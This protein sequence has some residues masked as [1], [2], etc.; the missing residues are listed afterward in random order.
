M[1]SGIVEETGSVLSF[2]PGAEAWRLIISATAVTKDLQMGDSIAVNGC[3]LTAVAF[4]AERIEFDLLAETVRLT[5]FNA[6]Q[7][8]SKVNL[9]RSLRF[10]GKLGGHFVTGHIDAQGT[11]VTLEPRGQDWYL[12]IE[13]PAE[14]M[15]YLVYKGSI[16]IDGISLTVADVDATGFSVWIIPH[17]R[18]VTNL[19][20]RKAGD[21]VNLEFDLLAKYVERLIAKQV[22]N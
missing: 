7:P 4:S 8:G 17:T 14:Y 11:L 10:D 9:E 3:C 21:S 5:N 1:F 12:R 15:H 13:P 18:N 6:L 19:C 20:T 2:A 16:A 22:K